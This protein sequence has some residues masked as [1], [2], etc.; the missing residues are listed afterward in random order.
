MKTKVT[1]AA[2]MST[3]RVLSVT[4]LSVLLMAFLIGSSA[5]AVQYADFENSADSPPFQQVDHFGSLV[6]W[7]YPV[8][9]SDTSNTLYRIDALAG[10]SAPEAYSI[11]TSESYPGNVFAKVDVVEWSAEA[12][13]Y[14]L[15]GVN[16]NEINQH[17]AVGC[18][19]TQCDL[20][21]TDVFGNTTVLDSATVLLDSNFRYRLEITRSGVSL[22]QINASVYELSSDTEVASLSAIDATFAN[23][24]LRVAIRLSATSVIPALAE[25]DNFYSFFTDIPVL[26][27]VPSVFVGTETAGQLGGTVTAAGDVDGD[28]FED[29][30]VAAPEAANA[31]SDANA[32]IV[33]LYKGSATGLAATPAWQYEGTAIG[34]RVGA[35]VASAGDVNN[36]SYD[37]VL[38]STGE[39]SG[40][41]IPTTYLFLGSAGGLSTT[42]D[43][44]ITN[45]VNT[46]SDFGASLLSLGDV[47]NDGFE[48]VLIG[49]P[50]E[51]VIIPGD[52]GPRGTAFVS[53]ATFDGNDGV[54]AMDAACAA[55]ATTQGFPGPSSY[56][57]W[58]STSS[59]NAID[60]VTDQGYERVD[61]A[62]IASSSSSELG[63]GSIQNT[64][65]LEAD[66]TSYSSFV[67]TGTGT[68]GT[69]GVNN[70]ANWSL[71]IGNGTAGSAL[72]NSALWTNAASTVGCFNN[73]PVYCFGGGALVPDP[74]KDVSATT[75]QVWLYFGSATGINTA[76]PVALLT[77][78]ATFTTLAAE[79]TDARFGAGLALA[80][81]DASG[82]SVIVDASGGA[83]RRTFAFMLDQVSGIV[84]AT[85][86]W[87]A[88][89]PA[90]GGVSNAV[91]SGV[92]INNDGFDEILIGDPE[93][94]GQTGRIWVYNGSA[95]PDT[96]IDTEIPEITP[97]IVGARFGAGIA[98]ADINLD[99]YSDIVIT[100]TGFT[101]SEANEGAVYVLLGSLSGLS[102][103]PDSIFESD[104]NGAQLGSSIALV[105]ING[106]GQQDLVTGASGYN[107]NLGAL[108]TYSSVLVDFDG[109]GVTDTDEINLHNTDRQNRDTD[110]DSLLDG[111]EVLHGFDPVATDE[112]AFDT[113][114]DGL[115]NLAE[116]TNNT[117]PNDTDT[118]NDG[119]SDGDEVN[120]HNTNPL[121]DDTDSD[122]LTD[123]AELST[124]GTDPLL[125]DSDNDALN[126]GD[127]LNTHNTNPLLNDTDTDGLLD[128]FEI[129]NGFDALGTDES[130][131]DPDADSLSNID[132]QANQTDPNNSDTDGDGLNDGFEVQNGYNPLA[133]GEQT[134]DLDSDGL[135]NGAEL[136]AGTLLDNPDTDGDGL[137][138]GYEVQYGLN[139]LQGGQE[140]Q[141]LDSDGLTTLQEQVLGTD[142]LSADT[143]GDG[144][145]DALEDSTG[146]DPLDASDNII[147]RR[148]TATNL[149]IVNDVA[150]DGDT[151]LLGA[152]SDDCMAGD[153]CGAAYVFIRS[154]G[155]WVEQTTLTANDASADDR[156]GGEV[157]LSGDT[158]LIGADQDQCANGDD[159]CGAA[160][161]FT[162]N[163]GVWTQQQKLTAGIDAAANELFGMTVALAGDTAIVGA[164]FDDCP[165]A[166]DCGTAY[167]FVR[168][169][170][171]VWNQQGSKLLAGDVETGARFGISVSIDG[172]TAVV[173]A[174]DED[175]TAGISCGAAYVFVRNGV[176]WSQQSKLTASLAGAADVADAEFG[177]SVSLSGDH[178]LIGAPS[179]T[180]CL[181]NFGVCAPAAYVFTRFGTVWSGRE[182]ISSNSLDLLAAG[183]AVSGDIAL[184]GASRD[185]TVG[186][187]YLFT[188]QGGEWV[189]QQKIIPGGSVTQNL[190]VNLGISGNSIIASASAGFA[191]V[192]DLDVDGDGLLNYFEQN[193]NALDFLDSDQDTNTVLDGQDD[194]DND[195]LT[196][197]AEQALGTN[198]Q[199]VDTDGDGFD[200]LLEVNANTDPLNAQSNL[201]QVGLRADDR[202]VLDEFGVSVAVDGNT[203][204]IGSYRDD[205][206]AGSDC[207]SAY[208]FVRGANGIWTQHSKLTAGVDAAAQDW[209]GFSVA[210]EGD[211]ALIGAYLDDCAAG[212]DCG[213]AYVFTRDTGGVWTQQGS[214]L[215]AAADA[216]VDDRFGFSV[217]LDSDTALIG[218]YLDDCAAGNNCGSAYVFTRDIGGV[219]TQQG[220]K[221]TASA[222]QANAQFG[223]GVALDVD[224]A[225]VGANLD[226]CVAGNG[227]GSAFVFVRDSGGVWTQQG[228][229]LTAGPDATSDDQ[230]GSNVAIDG[231][232]ILVGAPKDFI[233]ETGSPVS[234]CGAAYVFARNNNVWSQQQR[235][236]ASDARPSDN[237][238]VSVAV[239]GNTVLIGASLNNVDVAINSGSTYVFTRSGSV[240]SE[241]I[242]LVSSDSA[243]LDQFGISVAIDSDTALI[244]VNRDNCELGSD[245]GK[246]EV[247]LFDEDAD[248]VGN[249]A[250]NCPLVANAN[251][252]NNDFAYEQ[253]QSIVVLGDACDLDDNNGN[254][255]TPPTPA[256]AD[257]DLLD[258]KNS[259]DTN[260]IA[261]VA[262]SYTPDVGYLGPNP[263]CFEVVNLPLWATLDSATGHVSGIPADNDFGA[264]NN[265]SLVATEAFVAP[266][267]GALCAPLAVAGGQSLTSAPFSISVDD[268]TPP[269]VVGPA[270]SVSNVAVSV[271]LTCF[272]ALGS[273]CDEIY[274]AFDEPATTSSTALGIT[275]PSF[276]GQV[277]VTS[278]ST[279]H[280]IAVDV[281]GNVSA[282]GTAVF[283]VD[284]TAPTLS[285]ATPS[286]DVTT[287]SVVLVGAVS[288]VDSGI[289]SVD[290]AVADTPNGGTGTNSNISATIKT[291][292]TCDGDAGDGVSPVSIAAPCWEA[293]YIPQSADGSIDV[294]VTALDT[295]G[296]NN[297]LNKQF[298]NFSGTAAFTTL[299]LNLTSNSILFNGELDA[300]L[301]LT[302]EG[303]VSA[304]LTGQTVTLTITPP[305]GSS[306]LPTVINR[307]INSDGQVSLLQLGDGADI[308][309]NERGT[310]SLQA[311][312]AGALQYASTNSSA[313]ALLVGTSAG[314]AVLI[315]GKAPSSE[316]LATHNK[317]LNRVYDTLKRRNFADQ[318]IFYFNYDLNQDVD[319][320]GF[321]DNSI[322][323]NGGIDFDMNVVGKLG[324]QQVIESLSVALNNNPAPLY[325][326]MVDHGNI[327]GSG[328]EFLIDNVVDGNVSIT[329]TELD[330][331]LDTM[332]SNLSP[333]AAEEVR[334]V[335][336][337][338]CYAGGFID[339][340]TGVNG[341][342][343]TTVATA[344]HPTLDPLVERVIITSAAADEVSYKGPLEADGIRVGEYF[345]EELFDQL[346]RGEN[347]RDAFVVATDRTE[348]FTRSSDTASINGQFLD[349][350]VQHPLICDNNDGVGS[351]TIED[352]ITDNSVD[353][354]LAKN[355]FLGTSAQSSTNSLVEPAVV[356]RTTET[357]FLP[358][359]TTDPAD[360]TVSIVLEANDNSEVS[361][362][363]VEIR[364]PATNLMG[365]NLSGSGVTEQLEADAL[366]RLALDAPATSICAANEFCRDVSTF[367]VPGKYEIYYY[368][369]DQQ[370]GALSPA[371]RS[372]VYKQD[373]G[374]I[375]SA[376]TFDLLSPGSDT[377]GSTI[378]ESATIF[379]WESNTNVLNNRRVDADNDL[380]T[381][382]LTLCEDALLTVN[383]R[384]YEEITTPFKAVMGLV[385]SRYV[386]G[387]SVD[388]T[389]YWQVTAIDNF[390]ASTASTSVF[391]FEVDDVNNLVGVV[392]GLVLSAAN[393]ARLQGHAV[394]RADNATS[395]PLYINAVTDNVTG[396]YELLTLSS[397]GVPVEAT[398]PGFQLTATNV[399]IPESCA[400]L[401]I[402][403]GQ[404][405]PEPVQYNFVM[406]AS[407]VDSDNDGLND[408]VETNTGTFVDANDTGSDPN[409]SDTDG[410]GL[411]DGDEVNT[412][413]TD[414][415][416]S[417][418]DGDGLPD[419][420][421][422]A[423]SLNPLVDDADLDPDND[424]L[425]N[426]D[427]YLLGFDP[428][429]PNE[430]VNVPLP[431]WMLY[432]LGLGLVVAVRHRATR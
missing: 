176:A 73:N 236:L 231:D 414:P 430:N 188:L 141:D 313:E 205:C 65:N 178:V 390:G 186:A 17:Y 43:L 187:V 203:A 79:P 9:P 404:C 221:L 174:R 150:I 324:V 413:L 319:G 31:A 157:A 277:T 258:L 90:L 111:F 175:C 246:A 247:I 27:G 384:K 272:E 259:P 232:V 285:I 172:D 143:D 28:G 50:G 55:D 98:G 244:G 394:L 218:A 295:A 352:A 167:I 191:H 81:F 381:Y 86:Y 283:T 226:D 99:G 225:L 282:E 309:F 429:T 254:L 297:I 75:G 69:L 201:L 125:A 41:V 419:E 52:D 422:V 286:T 170:G 60:R 227:C 387:V 322:L 20:I 370:T 401:Q 71:T 407:A 398:V 296:N 331:W 165:T 4:W 239:S 132:E 243:F 64:I 373:A 115:N 427:E 396:A 276:N 5:H 308:T 120:I 372:L 400:E 149:E 367:T 74:S 179:L 177:Y 119:L 82:L 263:L 25:F 265:I 24:D 329:P 6:T 341:V 144:L 15:A 126:D 116:Q 182:L 70:C 206:V 114:T 293:L 59:E 136:V 21:R 266:S 173:G 216:M 183:V 196:N 334:I 142:P 199:L 238:G 146:T 138:D 61:S 302:V 264:Y 323:N 192:F 279:L 85:P 325:L 274:Y 36:D 112:S 280:F 80:Q 89:N 270:D 425:T 304:D 335:I 338:S 417:D 106:D 23:N 233:C 189:Q 410:D 151:A 46:T 7:S 249:S 230:F 91:I 200:D 215:T 267:Q 336:N 12:F 83:T 72:F 431:L 184:V 8:D 408:D 347:L 33:Y 204:L 92:D 250:D 38:V 77:D 97:L 66:G 359:G 315:Q 343:A 3:L 164:P 134:L 356:I 362:A 301:A 423:N 412:H 284:A 122:G 163:A 124:H 369:E 245:C 95:S 312:Y 109:D 321:N 147:E 349:T 361:V 16:G 426:I 300:A 337:G 130:A 291:S 358:A 333:E 248:L 342:A 63:S 195:G 360:N 256:E 316:G 29:I 374:N 87:E 104:Q 314:Y 108:L 351:N 344:A 45:G 93:Y 353:G 161:V 42:P 320:D 292:G 418:T 377:P 382:T 105:D 366:T 346:D 271:T 307:T 240:W 289:A 395:N 420:W 1:V 129:V 278:S 68:N 44:S 133:Q 212:I 383:C 181:L 58:V 51:I 380:V 415:N 268:I 223:F 327:G 169:S 30:L 180:P 432:L 67:W 40:T 354:N 224:T 37:D 127:E 305:P 376:P 303:N 229:K 213:S 22:D 318:N 78:I 148:L 306:N 261:N 385:S 56:K 371:V 255:I 18:R 57:A 32:G 76:S 217:A 328:S 228:S 207:G 13:F 49:A 222:A 110:G 411:N 153:D 100:D 294:Q 363:F 416:N 386:L 14:L 168:D 198:P 287:T 11:G 403:L 94:D 235:L 48:D 118:D 137:L 220:G 368:V 35:A 375:S 102:L 409:N 197:L 185:S 211:T 219:W 53:S 397:A 166:L 290:L 123:Q 350:A 378:T 260:V 424:G 262:Y 160:Y 162:R 202:D 269:V 252:A 135:A 19:T 330:S 405:T 234:P 311:S 402:L 128:G 96:V 288:D 54:S 121:S 399:F 2:Q 253:E 357:V 159:D 145:S 379:R 345:M 214:K 389:Y 117:D 154:N 388:V 275:S 208:V 251:Q 210:L 34:L 103:S 406:A 101:N 257:F 364:S 355:L 273:G 156:F 194:F 113:D 392:Q 190:G 326:V 393:G 339:A 299:Q 158:A 84:T 421:E 140:N 365:G 62:V 209:F 242:N 428:N 332:E 26:S 152:G 107:A 155:V 317:T 310:W 193:N 241:Q 39:L 10:A 340:L 281:A 237:F 171:G 131:Q 47:N 391:S 88:Q 348:I 298:D 139:P